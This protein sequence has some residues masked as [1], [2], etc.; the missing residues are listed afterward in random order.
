VRDLDVQCATL[1]R[2]ICQASA[3]ESASFE[4]YL[5]RLRADRD[6]A[7]EECR[8]TLGSGRVA[9]LLDELAAFLAAGPSPAAARRWADLGARDGALQFALRARKRLRRLGRRAQH[10]GTPSRLHRLRIRCK[11]FRYLLECCEPVCDER[12]RR[13]V[14]D[15]RKLQDTLGRYQDA[16]VA[17]QRIADERLRSGRDA[18]IAPGLPLQEMIVRARDAE[19]DAA[20]RQFR[21]DWLTFERRATRKKLRKLFH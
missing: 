10:D 11:R 15:V 19:A 2:D 6:V 16:H 4:A 14:H 12:L 9:K 18:G 8:A 5:A 1:E 20:R 17:S 7:V 3:A 13:T 21:E